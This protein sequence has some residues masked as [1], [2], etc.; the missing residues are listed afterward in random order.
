MGEH[1]LLNSGFVGPLVNIHTGDA[2]YLHNFRS[3]TTLPSLPYARRDN[4]WTQPEPCNGYMQPFF[5]NPVS[6]NS[7]FNRAC[8]IARQEDS[9]CFYGGSGAGNGS[10]IRENCAKSKRDDRARDDSSVSVAPQHGLHDASMMGYGYVAEHMNQNPSS[11][12]SMQSESGTSFHEGAKVACN[13]TQSLTSHACST[14]QGGGAPWY[15]AHA[16][17]RKKRKPYS[18]LQLAELESEFM[19][20]EFITR[21]RRKE[22]SDRLN[23]T[24]QQVKIWFQNRRMKKKRLMLREQ[25]LSFF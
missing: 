16:R 3:S 24:D 11:C 17:N 21:Q 25:A 2:F 18:K 12:H 9:K 10:S 4:V 19:M 13:V 7:T 8:E 22:L 6:L 15:P 20:N 14:T 1:N 23:L 5:G